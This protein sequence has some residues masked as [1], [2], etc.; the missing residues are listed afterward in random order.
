MKVN[1]LGLGESLKE[2]TPN[3][4]ITVGVN[5]INKHFEVD[6]LVCVDRPNRFNYER[7]ETMTNS[8][9]KFLSQCSEW[10]NIVKNFEHIKLSAGARGNLNDIDNSFPF[11]NNSTFVAVCL[12]YKLGAKEISIF[13]ADFNTHPNFKDNGL[14]MVLKDF[15]RL[16]EFLKSKGVKINITKQSRLNGIN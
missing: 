6:Y 4:G 10:S 16:F 8:N 13:G 1:I 5:D 11:S 12:A 15:K 3:G 7:L 2:F 14:E 9:A